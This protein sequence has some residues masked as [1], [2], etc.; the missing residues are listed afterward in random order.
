MRTYFTPCYIVSI[1]NFEQVIVGWV[2]IQIL[3]CI[4]YN[5]T[6]DVFKKNF[7]FADEFC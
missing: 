2:N 1:A 4:R 6:A 5:P 3:A 7:N